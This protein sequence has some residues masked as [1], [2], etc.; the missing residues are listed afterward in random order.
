MN[1]SLASVT[2]WSDSSDV[3]HW[4]R[5]NSRKYKPFV[6]NRTALIQECTSPSQWRH[7]P[8]KA[9]PA[10]HLTRGLSPGQLGTNSL[11]WTG[12]EFLL[13]TET[14]WPAVRLPGS[15]TPNVLKEAKRG[16]FPLDARGPK[17]C[18]A[19]EVDCYHTVTSVSRLQPERYSSYQHFKR[20]RAWVNRFV[21]NSRLTRDTRVKGELTPNELQAVETDLIRESQQRA[22]R[23]EYTALQNNRTLPTGSKLSGLSPIIDEDGIIRCA[24]RLTL[25][26]SLPLDV[27]KPIILPRD[28]PLTLLIIRHSHEKLNHVGGTNHTLALLSAKF[29]IPA[30]REAI[31]S[32]EKACNHCR[33]VKAK[34]GEQI[35]APLPDHRV[36][37]NLKPFTTTAVDFA[38]PFLTMQG[39]GRARVKRYMCLFT[40]TATRAVHIEMAYDLSTDGFINAFVR[41]VSRRGV[42]KEIISDNGTNFVG[43]VSELKELVSAFDTPRLQRQLDGKVLWHFNPPSAPHFGGVHESLIKSAKRAV[44]A[45]LS[46][47]DIRDEELV[48]CFT[49]VEAI[50]NSRPLTYQTANPADET[51]LTPNHFLSGQLGGSFAPTISGCPTL[52]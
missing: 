33:R 29:W 39:R 51:P 35:M 15:V 48:T 19:V 27:R 1:V 3:L 17:L 10:D 32:W 30:A 14:E 36:Q 47:A 11:W 50:L 26:E 16:V 4:I 43:A 13:L 38:G 40:C 5:G 45:I 9:N 44:Y 22:F 34:L 7:V 42:P 6:A 20:V 2:F 28:D 23:S 21:V 46:A 41:F 12:P 52:K 37:S 8:T 49:A 25:A 18:S 31:R 24:G